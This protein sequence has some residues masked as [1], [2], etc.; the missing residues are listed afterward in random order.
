MEKY[1]NVS[2]KTLVGIMALVLL[3]LIADIIVFILMFFNVEIGNNPSNQT[4]NTVFNNLTDNAVVKTI[5]PTQ[6]LKTDNVK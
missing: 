4:D 1:K 6:V 2:Q 5:T 3:F